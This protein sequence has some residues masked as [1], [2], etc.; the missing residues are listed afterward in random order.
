MA[1]WVAF[2]YVLLGWPVLVGVFAL[3]IALRFA[4]LD[5]FLKRLLFT[6]LAGVSLWPVIAASVGA[7]ALV[8]FAYLVPVAIRTGEY[9]FLLRFPVQHTVYLI[10]TLVL[11]Y[12]ISRKAFPNISFN[13]DASSAALRVRRRGAG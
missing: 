6:C 12:A 11:C 3:A 4:P 10:V 2:A 1:I 13:S 5:S 9:G 7:A 8:P